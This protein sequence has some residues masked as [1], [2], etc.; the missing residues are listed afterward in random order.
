M[1]IIHDLLLSLFFFWRGDISGHSIEVGVLSHPRVCDHI[2][3]NQPVSKI[4][5]YR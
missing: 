5:R 1:Y 3:E 2:Y 4:N